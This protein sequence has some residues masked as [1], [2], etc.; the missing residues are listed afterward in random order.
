VKYHFKPLMKRLETRALLIW[1]ALV[2]ALWAFLALANEIGEGETGTIDQRLIMMMRMPGDASN[3]LG[4]PW[5][6]DSMRDITALGGVTVLSLLTIVMV[7]CLILH[8]KRREG[9]ILAITAIGA[10]A[11]IE[12]LKIIYDRP[13]PN[14]GFADTHAYS[15]SFPSGH[16]TESTAIFL[17][18]AT[19]IATLETR[20]NTQILAYIV[21]IF[22]IIGVG[23]SRIYLGMHWP[24]DVLGGWVLGAAWALVAWI[25]LHWQ[26]SQR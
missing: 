16:T 9:V 8:Q 20:A 17:T 26:T 14:Q 2:F 13:R 3:P 5:L 18:A 15:T 24:T 22:A 19:V 25:A 12:I 11:S 10:Q 23:F 21:A 7:V 1:I 4:P 6:K